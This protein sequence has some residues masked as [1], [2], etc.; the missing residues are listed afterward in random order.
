VRVSPGPD[1]LSVYNVFGGTS[2]PS[3]PD[4][5]GRPL[6]EA[7]TS[8]RSTAEWRARFGRLLAHLDTGPAEVK[9][10][11]LIMPALAG[12]AARVGFPEPPPR[13]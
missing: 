4:S 11:D 6:R 10:G 8:F 13:R 1:P 2:G 7:V 12:S 5:N 9:A 3:A